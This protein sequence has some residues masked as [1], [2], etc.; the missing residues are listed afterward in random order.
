SP[1]LRGRTPVQN[2]FP[3]ALG[4]VQQF[5]DGAASAE[6]GAAAF[7][8][9]LT[10]VKSDRGPVYRAQSAF[11]QIRIR[12]LDRLLAVRTNHP[13][14]ALRQNAVE[15]RDEV[16]GLYAHVEEASQNV[17]YVV[18]VYRCEH[19]VAGERGVDRDLGGFLV[20]DFAHHD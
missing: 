4:K 11:G 20:A 3:D 18:G 1:D 12:V 15:R 17:Q 2:H 13:D 19:Q 16:I 7:K 9:S 10:F 14:Q 6:S 5:V 8:A